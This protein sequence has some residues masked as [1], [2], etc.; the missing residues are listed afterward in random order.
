MDH[1]KPYSY[2]GTSRCTANQITGV[3]SFTKGVT[4]HDI[5]VVM[6]EHAI[7]NVDSWYYERSQTSATGPKTW[8]VID[9]WGVLV[10]QN[11]GTSR[12]TNAFCS[13]GGTA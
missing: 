12:M 2:S 4:Y 13:T 8:K 7:N 5:G 6:T 10:S 11:S 1:I 3:Y 9:E